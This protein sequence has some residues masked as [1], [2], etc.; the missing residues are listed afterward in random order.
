MTSALSIPSIDNVSDNTVAP[1]KHFDSSPVVVVSLRA[2]LL[3]LGAWCRPDSYSCRTVRQAAQMLAYL[4]YLLNDYVYQDVD[5]LPSHEFYQLLT[6]EYL[7]TFHDAFSMTIEMGGTSD[8]D[9]GSYF[10][11]NTEKQVE[12]SE[13][14][15]IPLSPAIESGTVLESAEPVPAS[16]DTGSNEQEGRQQDEAE[17]GPSGGITSTSILGRPIRCDSPTR[18]DEG[19]GSYNGE[20]F[21]ER[22]HDHGNEETVEEIAALGIIEEGDEL[23]D[24]GVALEPVTVTSISPEKPAKSRRISQ[25]SPDLEELSSGVSPTKQRLAD[26]SGPAP[27]ASR[28]T[29]AKAGM[30]DNARNIIAMGYT[31]SLIGEKFEGARSVEGSVR[32]VI[33][34]AGQAIEKSQAGSVHGKSRY[35]GSRYGGS[36]FGGSKRS[37]ARSVVLEETLPSWGF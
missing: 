30:S 10:R 27:R 18:S 31:L 8:S 21:D 26:L 37:V 23:P 29:S 15:D 13:I 16:P 25:D 3:D 22:S 17:P 14:E 28:S 6:S 34:K 19:Y 5:S 12:P 2:C 35:G 36:K 9:I 11:A 1:D 7:E 32:S 4:R 24:Y 20:S 33:L